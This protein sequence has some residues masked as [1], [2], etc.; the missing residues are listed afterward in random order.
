MLTRWPVVEPKT[1]K[2][3]DGRS[4]GI[5][6][7]LI[8]LAKAMALPGYGAEALVGADGRKYPLERAEDWYFRAAANIAFTGKAPVG[9][10]SDDDVALA[11]VGRILPTL[12]AI[13][14]EDEVKKVAF[15]YSRGGRHQPAPEAWTAEGKAAWPFDKPLNVWNEAVGTARDAM[16]G[17]PAWIASVAA[18]P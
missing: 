3:A 7:F 12:K 15:L 18:M 6:T 11:G 1:A 4:I 9:D 5:E 2:T 17:T 14:P 8:A 13:L 16:T 10:A